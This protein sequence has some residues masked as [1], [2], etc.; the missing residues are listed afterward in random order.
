MS[1]R[2]NNEKPISIIRLIIQ[3][4]IFIIIALYI[5]S[6]I[7]GK[8][9]FQTIL[10]SAITLV[11]TVIS[12]VI[13]LYI[14][15]NIFRKEKSRIINHKVNRVKGNKLRKSKSIF[16]II[17]DALLITKKPN[18]SILRASSYTW[19]NAQRIALQS[20]K[21]KLEKYNWEKEEVNISKF[22]VERDRAIIEVAITSKVFARPVIIDRYK[23]TINKLGDI[24][25]LSSY[26]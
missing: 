2:N 7:S 25:L 19:N 6:L 9:L 15:Y 23:L 12:G 24:L 17:S 1:N 4:I 8:Q 18:V 14:E 16:R 11:V 13:I 3:L 10:S 26:Q 21:D 5:F 20:L 22:V